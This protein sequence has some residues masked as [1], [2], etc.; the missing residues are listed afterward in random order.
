MNFKKPIIRDKNHLKFIASIPCCVS[1]RGGVQAAHIRY[2]CFS[3]GM[4]PGDNYTV[5]LNHLEHA[6][7]HKIGESQFWE[8]I[9]NA[10]ALANLLYENTGN[11]EL[12]LELIKKFRMGVILY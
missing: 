6:R 4:K 2:G 9:N 3:M 8:D 7:Q 10:M 11:R 1:G 5:P 12:C